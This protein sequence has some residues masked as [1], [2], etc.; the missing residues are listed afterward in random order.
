MCFCCCD[1]FCCDCVLVILAAICPPVPVCIKRGCCSCDFFINICLCLLGWVPGMIH[2]WY[3]ILN[4][5]TRLVDDEERQIFIVTP[6]QTT[7]VTIHKH[8]NQTR[9]KF[10]HP[11][12][13]LESSTHSSVS[14]A[15][16]L[17]GNN[18][19]PLSHT[20]VQNQ[21][22]SS[23][24]HARV[25]SPLSLPSAAG[26]GTLEIDPNDSM[27]IENDVEPPSYDVVMNDT[28]KQFK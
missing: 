6:P 20:P 17:S 25:S 22:N 5:P 24:H 11:E 4:N 10:S 9:I 8:P 18:L 23:Q 19:S 16:L 14:N 26:Y 7:N 28:A 1:G 3:I 12:P 21:F 13:F 15:A 2:A 27:P